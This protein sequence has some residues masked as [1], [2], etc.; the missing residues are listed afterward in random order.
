V[1]LFSDFYKM[2]EIGGVMSP[3]RVAKPR[4]P[5]HQDGVKKEPRNTSLSKTDPVL[6]LS[7]CSS[8]SSAET[9][10]T[11][12]SPPQGRR[13]ESTRLLERSPLGSPDA[14]N[15]ISDLVSPVQGSTGTKDLNQTG[16]PSLAPKLT[17]SRSS[18]AK[19]S[20]NYSKY[21]S[22]NKSSS[23]LKTIRGSRDSTRGDDSFQESTQSEDDQPSGRVQYV[24]NNP[25]TSTISNRSST[26]LIKSSIS[27]P[28]VAVSSSPAKAGSFMPIISLLFV[29]AAAAVMATSMYAET[30]PK[31]ILYAGPDP[32][33]AAHWNQTR[34]DF[35]SNLKKL[36]M[37]MPKQTRESWL[38][39]SSAIKQTLQPIP[40]Y[41]AVLLL[42]VKQPSENTGAC[43]ASRL[44]ATAAEALERPETS[45][46]SNNDN[47][48][49]A[50]AFTTAN[51]NELKGLL[52]DRLHKTLSSIATV[53]LLHLEKIDP[54]V[55]LTL[56]AFTDNSNA[57]YKQAALILTLS[58]PSSPSPTDPQAPT[59]KFPTLEARAE[60]F[61]NEVWGES[62]GQDKV[63]ALISR[64]A[65]NVVEVMPEEEE[66]LALLCP[67]IAT[68]TK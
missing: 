60:D 46:S 50:E 2:E 17:T 61:L 13:L 62:M 38:T 10:L 14:A 43:L 3:W 6:K 1:I 9:C 28:P 52:T 4:K 55:A 49:Q 18:E 51:T 20:V 24:G 54:E 7:T 31:H 30:R 39:I 29:G 32:L 65:V 16:S 36:R 48:I 21:R 44:V 45:F 19:L 5:L 23:Q 11:K 22:S 56:H 8:H 58:D 47:I 53:A 27:C 64:L 68:K 66:E 57:P 37:A 40:E 67:S 12:H 41:P 15:N 63:Y 59:S 35:T 26:S 25:Q 33:S 42:L 34:A